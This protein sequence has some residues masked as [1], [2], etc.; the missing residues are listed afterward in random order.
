MRTSAT[1]FK[2]IDGEPLGGNSFGPGFSIGWQNGPV[3]GRDAEGQPRFNG[4][5]PEGVIDAL[6]GRL[7]FIQQTTAKCPENGEALTSLRAAL[8]SLLSKSKKPSAPK[9][10]IVGALPQSLKT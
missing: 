2:G 3:T 1:H 5:V 4:A 9:I 8:A 10:Q 7:E 6:I